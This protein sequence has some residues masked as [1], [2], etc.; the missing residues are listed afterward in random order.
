MTGGLMHSTPTSGLSAHGQQQS[1]RK[2]RDPLSTP[3][4]KSGAPPVEGLYDQSGPA[5]RESTPYDQ[6]A[7]PGSHTP[8]T[9]MP[10]T[11][12]AGHLSHSFACQ[13][14]SP[15][16]PAQL[17]PFYL[18]GESITSDDHYDDCW[19][20]VFGFP[21]SSATYILQQFAQL[22]NIVKHVVCLF[23]A[24]TDYHNRILLLACTVLN[25][26]CQKVT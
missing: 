10:S 15:P 22:G 24:S 21:P 19:V 13:G 3:K 5:M 14:Q 23:G 25:S 20:T 11:I 9:A 2:E 8:F 18:H 16:S 6:P 4:D 1:L 12:R 7:Q 17:D 26:S